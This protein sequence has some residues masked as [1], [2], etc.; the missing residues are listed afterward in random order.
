MARMFEHEQLI[1]RRARLKSQVN[2]R[3]LADR[4]IMYLQVRVPGEKTL[5]KF[6]LEAESVSEAKAAMEEKQTELRDEKVRSCGREPGFASDA[7]E[8]LQER[9][10]FL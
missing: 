1:L 5:R 9:P 8:D 3:A 4:R 10:S 2:P 7:E 6:P